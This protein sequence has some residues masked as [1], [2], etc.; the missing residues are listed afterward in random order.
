MNEITVSGTPY[1][2]GREIGRAFDGLIN[3]RLRPYPDEAGV[4]ERH[5]KIQAAMRHYLERRFPDV[6]EEMRGIADGAG[7]D[8]D[9]AF[10]ASTFNSISP[11]VASACTS[12]AFTTSDAGPILGKTDDGG[13]PPDMRNPEGERQREED[14]IAGLA[15]TKIKAAGGH[16]VL[17]IAPVGTVWAECGLNDKGLCL[18]SSSGQPP[19]KG[20]DG[21]GIPQHIACRLVLRHCA[22][23]AEAVEFFKRHKLAG[24]GI[25]ISVVDAAGNAAAVE[26]CFDMSHVRRPVNGVVFATNHYTGAEMMKAAVDASPAHFSSP[27]FQNTLNR[28]VGLSREFHD[29]PRNL[30]FDLMKRTISS[31][32]RPG[33][34]CQHYDNNDAGMNTTFGAVMAAEGRYLWFNP[35]HPCKDD[36]RKYDL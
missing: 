25:N 21:E 20:Q 1:E 3:A 30:T 29:R 36:F 4:R 35:G 26:S 15:V 19:L 28:F 9:S 10:Y 16:A 11:A 24:K 22:D 32:R 8:F 7:I 18:G 12:V 2:C 6:I 33:A 5:L 14:R 34:L 23:V 27:Y 31:H 17:C 13:L